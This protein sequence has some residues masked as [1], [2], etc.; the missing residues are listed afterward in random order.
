[1]H[2]Q[3]QTMKIEVNDLEL[4]ILTTALSDM[5]GSFDSGWVDRGIA[6]AKRSGDDNRAKR[7]AHCKEKALDLKSRLL[8]SAV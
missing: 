3:Q 1:M 6:E 2:T 8:A 4:E 7:L 5:I